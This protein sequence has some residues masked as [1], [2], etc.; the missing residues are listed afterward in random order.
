MRFS[1]VVNAGGAGN[2][3]SGFVWGGKPLKRGV[4][5]NDDAFMQE[6]SCSYFE[7]GTNESLGLHF[8]SDCN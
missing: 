1:G 8:G 5:E 4:N 6:L 3:F 2:R 7:L